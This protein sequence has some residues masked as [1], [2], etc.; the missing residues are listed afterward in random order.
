MKQDSS[1]Y[2]DMILTLQRLAMTDIRCLL[3][4][5]RT[6]LSYQF[7]IMIRPTIVSTE[8][9]PNGVLKQITPI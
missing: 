9:Y 1:L 2:L 5:L 4:Q 3:I 6:N 8:V 7:T